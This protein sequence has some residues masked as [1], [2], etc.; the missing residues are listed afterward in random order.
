MVEG[1]PKEK[2]GVIVTNFKFGLFF[3]HQP[4]RTVAMTKCFLITGAMKFLMDAGRATL[5]T[6]LDMARAKIKLRT[7]SITTQ[8]NTDFDVLNM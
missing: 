7:K 5:A 3:L 6:A 4:D 2:P 8:F 1:R